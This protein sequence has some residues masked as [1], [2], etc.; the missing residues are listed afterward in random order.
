MILLGTQAG[1]VGLDDAGEEHFRVL[2]GMAVRHLTFSDCGCI[3]T[4]M[5]DSDIFRAA[6]PEVA[7]DRHG[8]E[9]L[10]AV[11]DL[12]ANCIAQVGERLLIGCADARLYWLDM[13]DGD[14]VRSASFDAV[15][16]RETWMTPWGGPPDVRSFAMTPD[17]IYVNVHVGGILRSFD[18]GQTWS[19]AP[20]DL[21][22]DVHQ[23][24]THPARPDGIC[25]AT[26]KGLFHSDDRGE[27]WTQVLEPFLPREYQRA[28]VADVTGPGLMLCTASLGPYPPGESGCEGM[29]FRSIDGGCTWE[30][31]HEGLPAHFHQNLDT[32][33]VAASASRPGVFAL[34]DGDSRLFLTEDGAASWHEIAQI[35]DV[36]AVLVT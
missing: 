28:V 24:C 33:A 6:S 1:V 35:E 15:D 30:A 10:G 7:C 22:R 26:A 5:D 27:T 34:H 32:F 2:A 21:D 9:R 25:A 18:G 8:W 20:G 36:R 17:A 13:A 12:R 3:L 14:P 16:T 29:I 31:A 4:V 19:Q 11:P 23:V